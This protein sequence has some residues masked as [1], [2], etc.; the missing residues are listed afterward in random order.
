MEGST[1]I[2]VTLVI[3]DLTEIIH[4]DDMGIGKEGLVDHGVIVT[5]G[6]TAII[7]IIEITE[8]EV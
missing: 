8:E 1:E 4:R 6:I 2:N 7:G 5:G 3:T